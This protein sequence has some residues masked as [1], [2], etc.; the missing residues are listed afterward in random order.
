[1]MNVAVEKDML[2]ALS[3]ER[4]EGTT[5]ITVSCEDY[6]TFRK[7][8][9]AVRAPDGTLCGKSGWNSDSGKG[10]YMSSVTLLRAAR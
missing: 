4:I 6:D 3:V 1:M 10:Y 9:N 2:V 8:P 5:C 7:L